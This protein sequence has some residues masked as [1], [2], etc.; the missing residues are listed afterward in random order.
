M[1]T[2][3]WLFE[4]GNSDGSLVTKPM[5]LVIFFH[6][7]TAIEPEIFRPWIDH[8]V[9]RGAVVI[10]PYYQNADDNILPE[11]VDNGE[12]AIRDALTEL[13]KPGNVPVDLNRVG[14]VGHS[15]GAVLTADYAAIAEKDGLPV[16]SVVMPVEPGGCIDCNE[17]PPGWGVPLADFSKIPSSA[18]VY[19]ITGS[20]DD[21]VGDAGAKHVWNGL[22]NVP[23]DQKDYII[24]QGDTHGFPLLLADHDF[25]VAGPLPEKLNTLD[26]YG[27]WKLFDLLTDC[28]FAN[29]GCDQAFGGT[30]AQTYMGE[31]SDGT[32][33]KPA[34]INDNPGE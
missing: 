6:G 28:G 26:W 8:T 16:P 10:Y 34:V 15:V 14:V 9:Q 20:D 18:R 5:P 13:A 31:W 17:L 33:V 27:T 12:T 24:V 21:F 19:V 7:Y 11:F 2:G 29:K 32:P 4:P 22:T 3:Y 30:E 1:P 25:P 23:A